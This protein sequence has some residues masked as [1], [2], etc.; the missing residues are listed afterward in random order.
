[1]VSKVH[2][3]RTLRRFCPGEVATR[4]AL[5]S[6]CMKVVLAGDVLESPARVDPPT[7]ARCGWRRYNTVGIPIRRAPAALREGVALAAAEGAALVCLQELTLSPYFAI[8]EAALGV[9]PEP[10]PGGPTHQFAAALSAEFGIPVHAS[11]YEAAPDGG[12]GFNTAIVVGPEGDLIAR[13]RK[14]HIP[15]HGRL[16]RGPLLPR[17]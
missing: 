13:S 6:A 16:L 12:L 8:T 14:L 10:L 9:E 5:R 15:D 2:E 3:G 7:R 4:Q 1:M 11:L 17:R